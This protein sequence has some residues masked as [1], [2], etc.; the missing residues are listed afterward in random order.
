MNLVEFIHVLAIHAM[1][2]AQVSQAAI[3]AGDLDA[4]DINLVLFCRHSG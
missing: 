3:T 2:Q 4:I 1:R